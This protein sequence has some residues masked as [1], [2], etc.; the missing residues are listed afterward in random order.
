MWPACIGSTSPAYAASPATTSGGCLTR[1]SWGI[2]TP[3][4]AAG[5][6]SLERADLARHAIVPADKLGCRKAQMRADVRRRA[7]RAASGQLQ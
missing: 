1:L 5:W 4:F 2:G 3:V 6:D 7:E